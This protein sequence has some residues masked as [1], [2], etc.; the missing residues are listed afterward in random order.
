MMDDMAVDNDMT[1]HDDMGGD[2]TLS[3]NMTQGDDN[4]G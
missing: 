2:M 4:T 1:M 3:D